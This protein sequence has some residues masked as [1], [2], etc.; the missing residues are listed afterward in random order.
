MDDSKIRQIELSSSKPV[1]AKQSP[2]IDCANAMFTKNESETYS[3]TCLLNWA[4]ETVH[5]RS[6]AGIDHQLMIDGLPLAC[7]KSERP[8]QEEQQKLQQVLGLIDARS[9]VG[10][11]R[12]PKSRTPSEH[13]RV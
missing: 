8:T 5:L 11:S 13:R 1:L 12:R 10:L 6:V 4:R 9:R 3:F 2:C 7:N